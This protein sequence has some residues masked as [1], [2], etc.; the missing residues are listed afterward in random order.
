MNKLAKDI[1]GTDV[2]KIDK[3]EGIPEILGKLCSNELKT[4]IV[5]DENDKMIGLIS[6]GD[7]LFKEADLKYP[8]NYVF[9]GGII[10]TNRTETKEYDNML[11]KELALTAEELMSKNVVK[12]SADMTIHEITNLMVRNKVS[13]IPV[14]DINGSVVGII[15]KSHILAYIKQRYDT[16]EM[17]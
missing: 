6:E 9:L 12:G 17:I 5:V 1:M 8:S 16:I 11:K 15:L 14:E 2:V 13:R 4:L 10:Y 7:V 3:S